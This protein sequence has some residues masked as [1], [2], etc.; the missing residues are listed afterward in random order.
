MTKSELLKKWYDQ[1]WVQGNVDAIDQFF[2][3]D[4][5]AEGLIPEMQVGADDFREFVTAFRYHLGDIRVDL[6]IVI[7][8]GDW[9]SAIVHVHT[10]R[11][12]NGAP[13]EVT[14]Q[15][16]VRVKN[17]KIVEA[18]NQFDLI[19]LFEQLGQMPEDTL[20]VCMTGQQLE[21]A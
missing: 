4:T 19:S 5:L 2:A 7:E 9:A 6:P 21:W 8:N 16:M 12:D 10:S 18:Y 20:P 14:G 15:V 3:S 11:A 17:S 1:V 13:I